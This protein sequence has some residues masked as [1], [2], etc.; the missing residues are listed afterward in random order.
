MRGCR[1]TGPRPSIPG[2][3]EPPA[4]ARTAGRGPADPAAGRRFA[5]LVRRPRRAPEESGTPGTP[6][7]APADPSWTARLWSAT[8][9]E[10]LPASPPV[11]STPGVHGLPLADVRAAAGPEGAALQ[12][13]IEDGFLAGSHMAFLLRGDAL[14]LAVEASD[15]EVL[16]RLRA[17]EDELRAALAARGLELERFETGRDGRDDAAPGREEPPGMTAGRRDRVRRRAKGERGT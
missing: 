3:L 15:G 2:T 7:G 9:R 11:P 14:E 13:T 16:A 4:A 12:F 10:S 8:A 1:E 17:R 5:E 6:A